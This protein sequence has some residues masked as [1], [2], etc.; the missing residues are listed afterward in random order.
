M[1]VRQQTPVYWIEN[2]NLAWFVAEKNSAR[3]TD[4]KQQILDGKA[5]H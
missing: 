3:H 2:Y 5:R 4:N 1:D